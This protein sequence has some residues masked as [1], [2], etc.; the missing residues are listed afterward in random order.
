M[1]GAA[2]GRSTNASILEQPILIIFKHPE[3]ETD[4]HDDEADVNNQADRLENGHDNHPQLY[5]M[6]DEAQWS[7][8]VQHAQHFQCGDI[9]VC[10]KHVNDG[11]DDNK[12]VQT[13]PGFS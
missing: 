1:A 11:H 7:D 10:Q 6:R 3:P 2:L 5:I 4:D 12:K 9:C 13:V 8:Q